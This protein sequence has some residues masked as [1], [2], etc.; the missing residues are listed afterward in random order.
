MNSVARACIPHL[1]ELGFTE[2]EAAAYTFLVQHSPATGYRVAQGIGKAVANTYKA[3]QSLRQKGA[4]I[5]DET[6]RMHCRAVP[7]A[8]LLN[9]LEERRRERLHDASRALASLQPAA[10]DEGVYRLRSRRQVLDRFRD[11]LGRATEVALIDVFPEPLATVREAIEAAAARGASVAAQV[12]EP[13]TLKGVEVVC[14][15]QGFQVRRRWPGQWL[16][17]VIDGSEHLIAFLGRDSVEAVWSRSVYLSWIY[18]CGLAAEMISTRL[19][20]A[21]DDG[22]TMA[23]LKRLRRRLEPLHFHQA[24]GYRLLRRRL[25]PRRAK[26]TSP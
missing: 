18:H 26:H 16:N 23:T 15:A 19:V 3:L 12:Y 7:P 20:A 24:A 9:L 1:V 2:I 21:M 13:V 11:M 25:A 4:V 5:A 10:G 8:E 22:V 14:R 17:V 6:G